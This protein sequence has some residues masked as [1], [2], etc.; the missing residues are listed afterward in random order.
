M[1]G[2]I[3]RPERDERETTETRPDFAFA[4]R[5]CAGAGRTNP[6]TTIRKSPQTSDS[7]VWRQSAQEAS[8]L[9]A[10]GV[11]PHARGPPG[12]DH[13]GAPPAAATG[14]GGASAAL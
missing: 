9:I 13:K 14:T 8:V 7:L 1:A 11:P 4:V 12:D 6:C 5:D 3:F 10:G 2:G